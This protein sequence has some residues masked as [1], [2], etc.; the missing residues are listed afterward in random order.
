[1]TGLYVLIAGVSATLHGIAAVAGSLPLKPPGTTIPLTMR[2]VVLHLPT[3]SAL[4]TTPPH[5]LCDLAAPLLPSADSLAPRSPAALLRRTTT[6]V[7]HRKT[8]ECSS[9]R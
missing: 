2:R 4:P 7:P 6:Y 9:R 8:S 1:M 3:S 5:P